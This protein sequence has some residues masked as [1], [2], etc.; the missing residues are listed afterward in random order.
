MLYYENNSVH[1]FYYRGFHMKDL[2]KH[3]IANAFIELLQSQPIEKITV[4]TIAETC[5]INRQTFYYHFADIYELMEWALD[6]ELKKFIE[7]N[8]LVHSDWQKLL[9]QLFRFLRSRRRVLLNAYNAQNRL[10][11][12]LFIMRFITP[13]IRTHL[14]TFP[15]AEA[16]SSEKLDFLTKVYSRILMNFALDWLDEG[17]PDEEKVSTKDYVTLLQSSFPNALRAFSGQ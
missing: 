10:Y 15:E 9:H 12:E 17:M 13:A 1:G 16:V 3:A 7:E 14:L 5:G 4:K 6:S 2:T 8:G 11:Y